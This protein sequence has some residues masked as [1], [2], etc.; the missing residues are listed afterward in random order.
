MDTE[1]AK[2]YKTAIQ[3]WRADIYTPVDMGSKYWIPTKHLEHLLNMEMVGLSLVGL[4]LRTRSKVVKQAVCL[5]LG[6]PIPTSFK[7]TQPRFL[8]QQLDIYTQKSL[9]L[10]VWNEALTPD[11]RYAIIQISADDVILNVRVV[12]GQELAQ[13][14]K[15]GT[16]TTKY[17]ARLDTGAFFYELVSIHDSQGLLPYV[18]NGSSNF[19]SAISPTDKPEVGSLLSVQEIFKR[20]S[21]LVGM[22]FTDPGKLQERNR[23]AELHRLV[24]QYLGYSRYEDNGQFPDVRHQ[25]LEVK[26]QTSPTIDL[27]LVLPNNTNVLGFR[28]LDGYQPLHCD[29]RYAIL[30]AQTNGQTV[31]L[32]HL[33]VVTG[34][35]FFTRFRQFSGRVQNQK[36]QITLPHDFFS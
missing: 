36:L 18:T 12:N 7:K 23:G 22:T 26:L 33:Y 30:Q 34:Q 15:T 17:Q 6:Y 28:C 11:R 9:N 24:C 35:D 20:L 31:E 8:G 32:T 5:A 4:P 10:Q 14:D 2:S 19:A 16:L 1:T 13:L 25:L 21:P 27:G 3:T 29:T